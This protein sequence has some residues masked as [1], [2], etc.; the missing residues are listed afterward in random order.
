MDRENSTSK[1]VNAFSN[2]VDPRL[3]YPHHFD[4]LMRHLFAQGEQPERWRVLDAAETRL[5]ED[6]MEV[7]FVLVQRGTNLVWRRRVLVNAG[8]LVGVHVV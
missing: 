6:G 3:H 5:D 8:R 2:A 1:P 7:E 4:H